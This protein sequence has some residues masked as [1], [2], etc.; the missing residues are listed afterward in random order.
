MIAD[1]EAVLRR[2]DSAALSRLRLLASLDVAGFQAV[3]LLARPAISRDSINGLVVLVV[4]M[5]VAT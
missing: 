4:V 3:S 5:V 1:H 2:A